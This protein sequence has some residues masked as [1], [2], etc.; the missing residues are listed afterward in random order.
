M[1][2]LF[3]EQHAVRQPEEWTEI[4][5]PRS[6]LFDL[7]LREVWRYRDLLVLFVKRDL[8]AQYRQT[9]LGPVWHVIQPVFT[10]I[11][12][13]VL[14]NQIAG[15]PTDGIPAIIFYMCGNAVWNYFSTCLSGT[16]NTFIANAGIFGKVYFPRL[17][18]PLSI[19]CSNIIKFAIQFALLLAVMLYYVI[20]GRYTISI[21]LHTLLVP[22]VLA[23]MAALGLGLGIIISSLTTKYR[24]LTVLIS[25]GVGLLMYVTPVAYSLSYV[26]G[27][28]YETL[29]LL[30]PLSSL[31][32]TFRYAVLGKGIFDPF[33]FG[34]SCLFTAVALF[35]GMVIFS[36]VEKT[37]M[38][39]V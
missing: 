19:V 27:K 33:W 38:D 9:V 23:V 6:K 35:A 32:E 18:T 28:S 14:F 30:N 22:V 36:K 20:I 17:I 8:A 1:E 5:T 34:Y 16:S 25:F 15:I 13:Y 12:F 2:N 31:T 37:F 10:T 24:D 29:V 39:T 3:I 7:R 21:G 4:I 26:K 11:M